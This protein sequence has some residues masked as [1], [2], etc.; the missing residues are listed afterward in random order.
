MRDLYRDDRNLQSTYDSFLR[1]VKNQG[2]ANDKLVSITHGLMSTENPF[3]LFFDK[4][5][6]MPRLIEKLASHI[7]IDI[8]KSFG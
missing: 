3:N 1:Y 2:I 4:C 5:H 6:A 7:A 8:T